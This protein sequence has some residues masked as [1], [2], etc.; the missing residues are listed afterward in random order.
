M[1]P[2]ITSL[3]SY[4]C[5]PAPPSGSS[6]TASSP[7]AIL[8]VDDDP[9]VLRAVTRL[10]RSTGAT[11]ASVT[12]AT[13][14]MSTVPP[15]P[16]TAFALA[17]ID[18]DLGDPDQDGI[19]LAEGLLHLGRVRRVVFYSAETDPE[20]LRRATAFGPVIPKG[21]PAAPTRFTAMFARLP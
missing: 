15:P 4:V 5:A 20:T 16:R 8:I 14:A 18:I 13:A 1:E 17:I 6:A 12:G 21:D 7:P 9:N 3:R 19:D 11:V 2:P 10:A